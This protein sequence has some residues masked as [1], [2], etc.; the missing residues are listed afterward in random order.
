MA[1]ELRS[2]PDVS[3][4]S[5]FSIVSLSIRPWSPSDIQDGQPP[6]NTPK[7]VLRSKGLELEGHTV[8]RTNPQWVAGKTVNLG[9]NLQE[10]SVS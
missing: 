4:E 2:T 5:S 1:T 10:L 7:I 8:C 9:L 6:T 3:D